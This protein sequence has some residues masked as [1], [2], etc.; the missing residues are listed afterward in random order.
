MTGDELKGR[1]AERADL[2][3]LLRRRRD[4]CALVATRVG[5]EFEPFAEDRRR[6]LDIVIDEIEAGLHLGEAV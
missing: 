2:L 1:F 4:N 5:A 6:Q 3:A